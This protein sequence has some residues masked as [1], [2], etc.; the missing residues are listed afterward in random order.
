MTNSSKFFCNSACEYFPCHDNNLGEDFNCL[1]C[2]CP[3]YR[4]EECLG[5]PTYIKSKSG[6]M[7]KDCSACSFPHVPGNYDKIMEYL[8]DNK[9]SKG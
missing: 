2:F 9:V 8:N 3:M 6:Q 4:M 7:I 1:F 5:N